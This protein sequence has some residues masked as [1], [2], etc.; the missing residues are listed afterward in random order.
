M[1]EDRKPAS[2]FSHGRDSGDPAVPGGL[3]AALR[4]H[5]AHR[6]DPVRFRY[7]EALAQRAAAHS[8]AVRQTLDR[9]LEQLLAAYGQRYEMAR[10]EAADAVNR[11]ASR[12][13]EAAG[14]LQRLLAAGDYGGVRR[15]A[16]RLEEQGR[17]RPLADLVDY[18]D[19]LSSDHTAQ[20]T[21]P[22]AA[23]QRV[24][25][26]A[27]LKALKHFRSTW[28]QLGAERQLTRSLA[29]APGN[30]GPLN[31]HL[32]VLRSLQ[33]MQELSPD[34]LHRFISH[35][36]ALLWLE[37]AGS[38]NAP[39]ADRVARRESVGKRKPGRGKPV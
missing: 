16:A 33:R 39:E 35:V 15:R 20:V 27:E 25:T 19:G 1:S 28:T 13:P 23:A 7:I 11:L 22:D 5:G 30:P 26:P 2:P 38:A 18:I 9:K 36:E 3:T 4:E 32:L 10:R 17:G 37:Q 24:A 21:V 6:F 34:Y 29:K 14:D 12:F 8:G 31:S